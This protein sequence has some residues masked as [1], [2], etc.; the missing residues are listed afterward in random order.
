M[1]R[2]SVTMTLTIVRGSQPAARWDQFAVVVH[3]VDRIRVP[4][5]L[6]IGVLSWRVDESGADTPW[7]IEIAVVW[8]QHV[9]WVGPLLPAGN[10]PAPAFACVRGGEDG[11]RPLALDRRWICGITTGTAG[12]S[13]N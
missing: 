10:C 8:A 13:A 9:S 2:R 12:R 4:S 3:M 11:S 5:C 1:R 6:D 7:L